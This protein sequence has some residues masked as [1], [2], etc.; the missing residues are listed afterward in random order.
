MKTIILGLGNPI[1][2]DDSV[3][4]CVARVLAGRLNSLEITVIE[5]SV[6]GLDILDLLVGYER[7]IIID[8]VQTKGGRP[9]Q[10]YRLD[11][12]ALVVTRHST[13]PH[14]V[15]FATALELSERLGLALPRETVIFG[16]EVAEVDSFSEECTPQV[17]AAI[18]V[19]VDMVLQELAKGG[20]NSL[21]FSLLTKSGQGEL[22]HGDETNSDCR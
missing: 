18:P 2:A 5:A 22:K 1:R 21:P 12:G 3:G 7:A 19:C 11:P 9:G 20:E 16:I 14:S 13:N 17:V 8:A 10:I 6:S 4:L 15:D